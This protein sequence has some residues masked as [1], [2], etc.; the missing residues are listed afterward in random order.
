MEEEVVFVVTRIDFETYSRN[1]VDTFKNARSAAQEYNS[2]LCYYL[3]PDIN[4]S[5]DD[6]DDS[7]DDE[8]NELCYSC[9]PAEYIDIDNINI[10]RGFMYEYYSPDLIV[11][12]SKNIFQ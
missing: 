9:K 7:E 5:S 6:S 3:I 8:S 11:I 10:Q 2:I 4:E 12:L 1:S